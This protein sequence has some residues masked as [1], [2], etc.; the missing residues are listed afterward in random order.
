M[1]SSC[2]APPSPRRGT[3][4]A[5]RWLYRLRPT[6]EH[7]PFERYDGAARFAP[8]TVDAP[9][10]AQPPA[11]GPARRRRAGPTDL[12]DGMTTMLANRDPADLEGVALHLYAANRGHDRPRLRRCR[13]RAAVR[14]AGRAARAAHR[15]RPDRRRAGADRADPARRAFRALL[16]DGAG[17]RLCRARTT[18]RCSACPISARSAPTASPTRAISRRRSPGSRIATSRREVIQKFM[19]SLWTTTLDHSPLDVVAWHGNLAPWRYDLA[20]FNTINTVSF[21]HPDPSIFTVLTSPSDV[22]G[23]RQRRF[24]DLPA[25]LDGGGGHVPPALVPPQR[26]VARRWG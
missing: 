13:W 15:A 18:A 5:A 21:D 26:D 20:R 1:P 23:P 4:T 14:P 24:R 11:L 2:R 16:P 10:A 19:G 12:I 8:G 6:A 22:P 9:L 25:A 3:R 7:P 17:A